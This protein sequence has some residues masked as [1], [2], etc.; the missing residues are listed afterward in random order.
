M[1][2]NRK[3]YVREK[4]IGTLVFIL[5]VAFMYFSGIHCLI[6]TVF[7][8]V[9]PG[10]GLTRAILAALRLDLAA[11]FGYNAMFWSVPLL[12]LYYLK[13]GRL[14]PKKWMDYTLL[15]LIAVGFL[16]NW[17]YMLAK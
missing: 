4:L 3:A 13:D 10:C 9:C 1:K 7:G 5:I 15:S 11:A 17:I 14:L 8:I 6:R 2:E 16:G 12:Y